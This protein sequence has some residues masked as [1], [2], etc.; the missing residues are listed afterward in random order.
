MCVS[1]GHIL[2]DTDLLI[3]KSNVLPEVFLKV[4]EAKRMLAAKRVKSASEAARCCGISRSA[5]YKYRDAV[6][7]YSEQAGKIVNISAVLEDRS[8]VLSTFI[9]VLGEMKINILT[10]NQGMPSDGVAQVTVSCQDEFN[11]LTNDVIDRLTKLDGVV[12]IH[13]V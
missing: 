11:I 10:I 5:F 13:Q 8:G 7:S 9:A 6:F 1:G 4:I 3:V 12:N 2:K